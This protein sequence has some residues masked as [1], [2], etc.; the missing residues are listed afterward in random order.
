MALEFR[1]ETNQKAEWLLD[2]KDAINLVAKELIS[3]RDSITVLKDKSRWSIITKENIIDI[4]GSIL[5]YCAT[6]ADQMAIQNIIGA[7]AS[8]INKSKELEDVV[9]ALETAGE[10]VLTSSLL[11]VKKTINGALVVN[12]NVYDST[13]GKLYYQKPSLEPVLGNITTLGAY[14]FSIKGMQAIDILREVPFTV[15]PID[16]VEPIISD[17]R[18]H[19][20]V[21]AW[22]KWQIRQFLVEDFDSQ[23]IYFDWAP[24]YRGRIYSKS[25]HLNPQGKEVEKAMLTINQLIELTPKGYVQLI[26]SIVSA[27]GHDK[28][29]DSWK[30]NWYKENKD[31][32]DN[33]NCKEPFIYRKLKYAL[34]QYNR[35]GATN[36]TVEMDSTNS[37]IQCVSVLTGDVK[38][39]SICNVIPTSDET[40][41]DAYQ[42][43]ADTMSIIE[44][45]KS[46]N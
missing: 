18:N 10:I 9:R 6:I 4:S 14:D 34:R 46:G 44:S 23:S 24:C 25:Y 30:I 11:T 37:Q 22:K 31:N 15:L 5:F 43:M 1:N 17:K 41:A 40:V 20:Q 42:V 28:Q 38:S 33:I 8:I 39:A 7:I 3:T 45:I 35:T 2:K 27:F 21:E 26:K 32:L 19:A 12:T 29:T 36:V 16:T 13:I